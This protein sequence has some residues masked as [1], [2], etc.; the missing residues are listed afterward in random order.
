MMLKNTEETFKGIAERIRTTGFLN[1]FH[2]D[3]PVKFIKIEISNSIYNLGDKEITRK[4]KEE[5]INQG[6]KNYDFELSLGVE[7]G[8]SILYVELK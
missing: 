7:D 8:S 6:W 2:K 5:I 4:V 1:E 3:Y